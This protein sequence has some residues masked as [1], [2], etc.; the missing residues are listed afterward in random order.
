MD[1]HG[2]QEWRLRAI[3][4]P[5]GQIVPLEPLQTDIDAR[6]TVPFGR[7]KLTERAHY[8]ITARILGRED[9]RFNSLADLVPEGLAL[10]WG[11]MSDSRVLNHIAISQSV[12]F[13]SWRA[14][15]A[16]PIPARDIIEHSADTHVI[17]ADAWVRAQLRRLRVGQVVHLSG[18]SS[19]VGGC[20]NGG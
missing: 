8:D 12:R 19:D 15:G 11:P 1:W 16:L 7:W 14:D 2:A 18:T 5:D 20:S 9:Y 6:A 13:Y 17:P 3:H 4:P 10:G